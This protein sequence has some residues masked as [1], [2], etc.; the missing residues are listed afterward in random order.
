MC[1]KLC[2]RRSKLYCGWYHRQRRRFETDSV[3]RECW[4]AQ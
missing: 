4:Y 3:C 1:S 2:C